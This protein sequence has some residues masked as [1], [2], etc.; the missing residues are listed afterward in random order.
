[1][2]N[3]ASSADT[4]LS[5]KGVA[6]N[7]ANAT[8][9]MANSI[10]NGVKKGVAVGSVALLGLG[11]AVYNVAGN[12]DEQMARVNSIS[13]E[14]GVSFAELR[15]QAI[16]LGAKTAFS[17]TEAAGG[18]EAMA[19]AGFNTQQIYDSMSGVLD[20]AA[21]SGGDV[22]MAAEN[23]GA[24][25]NGFG[26]EAS[27]A[28]HVADVFAMSAAK[29]NAE[30]G[31]MGEAMKYVAPQASAMGISLE[32]TAAAIGIMSDNGI[33]GSQAGTT[34]RG[35]LSRLAKPT[36]AMDDTMNALGISFYDSQGNMKSLKDQVGM[37][38]G[39]FKN[40]TPEQQQNALVTL[41]GQE[42]LSGMLSLIKEGPDALGEMTSALEN[43]NGAADEMASNMQNNIKSK[44]EQFF[45]S[46]ESVAIRIGDEIFPVVG[47]A[48][49]DFTSLIDNAF[50][51][52]NI[53]SFVDNASRYL[54]VLKDGF[55]EVKGPVSDAIGAVM[56]SMNEL[57]GAFGSDKSVDSFS[58]FVSGITD[59]IKGL[60]GFIEDHSDTIAKVISILP[61]VAMGVVAVN[62][63]AK[64]ASALSTFASGL[65]GV[66]KW[67]TGMA[68]KLI[69][70]ATGNTAIGATA[71]AAAGGTTAMGKA[72]GASVGQMLALGAAVLMI[73]GGI[74][75]AAAG[76]WI[77]AQAA[78]NLAGAGWGAVAVFFGMIIA[79]GALIAVVST[80]GVGLTAGAVGM[81]AFGAMALMVGIALAIA[82]PA[83]K[84]MPPLVIAIGIAFATTAI[85]V[86]VAIAIIIGAFAGLVTA[87]ADG[88]TQIV[89]AI[90][91]AIVGVMEQGT[92]MIEQV[93]SSIDQVITSVADG[94]T[95]ITDSV[96]TGI[97]N[98]IDS[99]GNAIS[100]VL[101]SVAGV[102]DSIGNSA[103][104]AGTGM[105]KMADA[106]SQIVSLNVFDLG[107]SLAAVGKGLG[108][109]ARNGD[110]VAEVG[111]SM[112]QLSSSILIIASSATSLTAV[113]VSIQT[114]ASSMSSVEGSMTAFASTSS[115]MSTAVIAAYTLMAT[116]ISTVSITMVASVLKMATGTSTNMQQ[117]AIAATKGMALFTAAILMGMNQAT[118]AVQSGNLRIIASM[119]QLPSRMQMIGV[120]TMQGL[121]NGIQ[122]G[123]GAAIAAAQSVA[124]RVSA[125]IQKALDVHSP[126]K[127][128]TWM[129][130]MLPEGLKVGIVDNTKSA[131]NAARNMANAVSSTMS[132]LTVGLNPFADIGSDSFAASADLNESVHL[133][134]TAI[135]DLK[136]SSSQ[137]V[138]IE[139]KKVVPQVS[140]IVDN[141]NGDIDEDALLAKFENAIEE[142]I[143][144]DLS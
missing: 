74:L 109:I 35:A 119:Q 98:V 93:G 15:E 72:A 23:A 124:S 71:P 1:M 53:S 96:S 45:G 122:A 79:I 107:T 125:T 27:Q 17:A 91:D 129:G 136:A 37:L 102:F 144:A 128:T 52:D 116:N 90:G 138:V 65:M 20:L 24:A 34:L 44:V 97:T 87:I 43:S 105:Q 86:G 130:E 38:Q 103:L 84:V 75:L 2:Q 95:S 76:F 139:N 106:I 42:S 120:Y 64:M 114:M 36:K 22:A 12:F 54:N 59:A 31:D 123:S 121:A 61:Q 11:A 89:T 143:D 57:N 49:E 55:N 40:L 66:A 25:L 63:G 140:I 78:I 67:T 33:K 46:L 104:N 69:G 19:S 58:D 51:A 117:M 60:A 133:D 10:I 127:L 77:L 73:G 62:K 9:G 88:V 39:A 108:D 131:I 29:T 28:G 14:V 21:V 30:V 118:S 50:T 115:T 8:D 7:I 111:A 137:K 80:F 101:D 83:I 112:Q 135:S 134:D 110:Q 5:F 68:L 48:I 32:E 6:D 26:L 142:M 18:M 82:T 85:A 3:F 100:G 4:N 41:Y 92:N 70:I 113:G 132:N 94:I 141:K 47:S 126:S 16:D 56:D 13:D 99:V 81:L